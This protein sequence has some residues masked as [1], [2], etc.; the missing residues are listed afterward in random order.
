MK[1]KNIIFS[2]FA[3]AIVMGTVDANAS[4]NIASKDYVD[5]L[6]RITIGNTE[7]TVKEVVENLAGDGTGSIEDQIGT[8]ISDVIGTLDEDPNGENG[9][10]YGTVGEALDA[11]ADSA[12][13]GEISDLEDAGFSEGTTV[14]GAI[15]ELADEVS[16]IEEDMGDVSGITGYQS[17]DTI[18][19]TINDMKTD[20]SGKQ[21]KLSGGTGYVGKVVTAGA[22]D[23]AVTYTTVDS[24]VG[25]N[26]NLVT[27]AAVQTYVG[28]AIQNVT[29]GA[30]VGTLPVNPNAANEGDRY[31]TVG[32]A[33]DD[34]NA[35]LAN[36]ANTADV[37]TKSQ[38]YTQ[39]EVNALL[40][41]KMG[42]P[43]PDTCTPSADGS[44]FCVLTKGTNGTLYWANI[45]APFTVE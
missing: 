8:A 17:G 10:S 31:T 36:K 38:T 3:A 2:G 37:Y 15:S 22:S 45:T 20:I 41:A 27:G 14:V 24:T 12:D 32:A 26:A 25:N 40:A 28:N 33:L 1:I 30:T 39:A 21:D 4:F 7:T 16:D 13:I 6:T 29:G 9:E 35:T 11:K 23:G 19:S 44:S 18:V 43:N 5:N 42:I 34:I